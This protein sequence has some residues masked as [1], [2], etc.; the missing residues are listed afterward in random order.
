[1]CLCLYIYSLLQFS[2]AL[3]FAC[4][5]SLQITL[6]FYSI[7][8]CAKVIYVYPYHSNECVPK[9]NSKF[10]LCF[11]ALS[12]SRIT[13]QIIFHTIQNTGCNRRNG[14]D[15]G[16]VFLMLNYTEKPQNTYIQ[17]SMVTEM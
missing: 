17:S 16:K 2:V 14:P 15:F 13:L 5:I 1:M 3:N 10:L 11:N 4:V 7:Y 8:H 9:S 6:N 12:E